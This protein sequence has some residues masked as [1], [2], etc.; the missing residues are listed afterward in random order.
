MEK[1]I[2]PPQVSRREWENMAHRDRMKA[3]HQYAKSPHI[4]ASTLT[5]IK[6]ELEYYQRVQQQID[7]LVR[8]CERGTL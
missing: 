4:N 8:R 6:R 3:L 7:D 1:E 2:V 5:D